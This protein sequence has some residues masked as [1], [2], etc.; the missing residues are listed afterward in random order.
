[1]I[2]IFSLITTIF[3][4]YNGHH[5]NHCCCG[6]YEIVQVEG[7]DLDDS[8]LLAIKKECIGKCFYIDYVYFPNI[9]RTDKY[10][11]LVTRYN[12]HKVGWMT[13]LHADCFSLSK[14]CITPCISQNG[15]R[16]IM[17]LDGVKFFVKYNGQTYYDSVGG[18]KLV[19]MNK[20]IHM[21]YNVDNKTF[22]YN[23]SYF[24]KATC[25]C[26]DFRSPKTTISCEL[27]VHT[28]P[29]GDSSLHS[30][31]LQNGENIE[32]FGRPITKIN[33][34]TYTVKFSHGT[35]H[36]ISYYDAT[37]TATP[38]EIFEYNILRQA[39]D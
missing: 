28:D 27:S 35:L 13:P 25:V 2:Y 20:I 24:V 33:K 32:F 23:S 7:E 19:D 39:I 14:I 16:A 37:F 17:E 12:N 3:T 22:L 31:T 10:R 38:K 6:K 34:N 9:K 26:S 1:M 4:L 29:N 30:C 11:A 21:L 15:K 8:T 18:K 5:P 36:H